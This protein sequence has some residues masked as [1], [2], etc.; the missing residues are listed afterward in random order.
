[1]IVTWNIRNMLVRLLGDLE[2]FASKSHRS[3]GLGVQNPLL[4][5]VG[6][7]K[8]WGSVHTPIPYLQHRKNLQHEALRKIL[9]F[10]VFRIQQPSS[11]AGEYFPFCLCPISCLG[12]TICIYIYIYVYIHTYIYIYHPRGNYIRASG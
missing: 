4:T 3:A 2:V 7:I 10:E 6:P 8:S 1:M 9:L 5:M 12:I 11:E